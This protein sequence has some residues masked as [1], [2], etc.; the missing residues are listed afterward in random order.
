MESILEDHVYKIIGLKCF[1][2][3][4]N[5]AGFTSKYPASAYWF[6]VLAE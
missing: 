6:S 1:I 4:K 2:I 5:L 3:R